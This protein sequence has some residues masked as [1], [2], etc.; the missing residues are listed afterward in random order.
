MVLPKFSVDNH[1]NIIIELN[2]LEGERNLE[3]KI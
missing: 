3:I 1:K 2:E